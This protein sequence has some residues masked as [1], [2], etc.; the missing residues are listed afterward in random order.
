MENKESKSS[1]DIN[2]EN[3]IIEQ[4]KKKVP[5]SAQFDIEDATTPKVK[6]INANVSAED[7]IMEIF[8]NSEQQ[9]ALRQKPIT[10]Y[11]LWIFAIQLL[12]FNAIIFFI[13]KKA[14][15]HFTTSN[16]VEIINLLKYYVGA[17]I[18]E[19]LSLVAVIINSSFNLKTNTIIKDIIKHKQKN[20]T[21]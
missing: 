8:I 18:V 7:K 3:E 2:I 9:K 14:L 16:F 15:G 4:L 19:L 1:F 5:N 13:V 20:R 17:V 21:L 11:I 12:V 10:K 6:I